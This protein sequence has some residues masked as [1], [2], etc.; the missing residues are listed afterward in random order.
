MAM[1][2]FEKV[3]LKGLFARGFTLHGE[4]RI[5]LCRIERVKGDSRRDNCPQT[6]TNPPQT[7][8]G[9]F[10]LLDYLHKLTIIRGTSFCNIHAK[11]WI[12]V[13]VRWWAGGNRPI[14]SPFLSKSI[15]DLL[16]KRKRGQK[17]NRSYELFPREIQLTDA[18]SW[19]FFSNSIQTDHGLPSL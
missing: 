6:C 17:K 1:A 15:K 7:H 18:V 9:E 19:F 3:L 4:L 8:R 5:C 12:T 2:V 10:M 14:A 11:P 16:W 13:E